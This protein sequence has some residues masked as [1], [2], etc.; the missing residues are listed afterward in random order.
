[1][2]LS[3]ITL[4][5]FQSHS[6]SEF[7]LNENLNVI[8]GISNSG[9]TS[10][11]RALSLVLFNQWDKSW[12]K[13]GAKY[14]R[15]TIQTN[16][17][18]QVVREKGEKV[19]RYI[20][21]L[22]NE[23]E[24]LFESFGTE[25]PE[26]IQQALR[27][28]EVQIDSTDTLNL[29]L[30]G[31]M[32]S[33]FLL[34]QTG[35]YRAKVLGKLSG[36]TYLDYAIRELNKEKRQTTAEKNSKEIELV[37]VQTQVDKLAPITAYSDLI[38]EI[39]AK[40]SSLSLQEDRLQ[41]IRDLFEQVKDLKGAWEREIKIEALIGQVDTSTIVDLSLKVDKIKSISLLWDKI[42]DFK[43]VFDHQ[44][45]LQDLLSQID[46]TSIPVLIEK[47][48]RVGNIQSL[49]NTLSQVS[50]QISLKEIDLKETEQEYQE[51]TRQYSDTLREAGVCPICNSNTKDLC[52]S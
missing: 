46:L 3:K 8:V 15:V 48:T 9:K 44:N 31:Q 42:T 10:I 19:N 22:P 18:I 33:L 43:S 49:S 14:C 45:K 39:E 26:S 6:H 20:L 23:S 7:S 21:R 17:G 40:L 35:S 36:A 29:N 27:I 11:A 28:H 13:F 52:V 34:S 1:M 5:N 25:V 51:T 4:E 41:R 37:E 50:T 47:S 24:Q 30:A 12:V 2:F 32:D 38:T 16:T